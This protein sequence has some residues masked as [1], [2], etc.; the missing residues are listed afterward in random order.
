[1]P[2][3]CRYGAPGIC[4]AMPGT[5]SAYGATRLPR[6]CT[7]DGSTRTRALSV[8]CYQATRGQVLADAKIASLEQALVPLEADYKVLARSAQRRYYGQSAYGAMLC[9]A[10]SG[11]DLAYGAT[12]WRETLGAGQLPFV[13]PSPLFMGTML[14]FMRAVL[15]FMESLL[16]LTE[17][18]L[19][20][21]AEVV[22]YS[23]LEWGGCS[24]LG[25][26]L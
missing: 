11:T 26:F 23:A 12:S 15:S 24:G 22:C 8:W 6:R 5:D 19:S 14:S 9:Y 2:R 21:L 7:S 4:S 16:P 1:M 17:S 13:L 3:L 18:M 25:A 20:S 10:L